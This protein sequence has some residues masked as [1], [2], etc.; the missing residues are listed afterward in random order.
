MS[1][2]TDIFGGLWQVHALLD[3]TRSQDKEINIFSDMMNE[4]AAFNM[5][6]LLALGPEKMMNM[7]RSNN[8]LVSLKGYRIRVLGASTSGLTPQAWETMK[9]FWTLYFHETGAEL[10]SYSPDCTI[11][12]Q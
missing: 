12:I 9:K 2:G 7:A 6:A 8:L 4:T 5:P 10:I 3:S 1:A 11:Q